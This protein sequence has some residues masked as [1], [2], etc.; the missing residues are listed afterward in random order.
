MIHRGLRAYSGSGITQILRVKVEQNQP[1]VPAQ[2]LRQL[3]RMTSPTSSAVDDDVIRP[4]IQLGQNLIHKD[5]DMSM[6]I[7]G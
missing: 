3:D 1:T 7:I 4:G 5:R 2:S 6:V